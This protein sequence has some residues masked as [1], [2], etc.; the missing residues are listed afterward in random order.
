MKP[1]RQGVALR[2]PQDSLRR[3]QGVTCVDLRA[4]RLQTLDPLP[5]GAGRV[6]AM[7]SNPREYEVEAGA[8]P[9]LHLDAFEDNMRKVATSPKLDAEDDT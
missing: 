1:V 3:W 6:H 5:H 2:T 8:A 9:R 4:G 7:D